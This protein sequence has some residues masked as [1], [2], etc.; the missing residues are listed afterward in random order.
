M[1]IAAGAG[2]AGVAAKR[3]EAET[4]T[5]QEIEGAVPGTGR[6]GATTVEG[7]KSRCSTTLQRKKGR[8][9]CRMGAAAVTGRAEQ[10]L[11]VEETRLGWCRR[12]VR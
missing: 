2:A 10:A 5:E 6:G 8:G 9:W 1:T 7:I 11:A 3:L 4:E 12:S